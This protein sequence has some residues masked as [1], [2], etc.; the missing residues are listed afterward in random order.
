MFD[1]ATHG[2]A[3]VAV[4]FL[5][6]F[7][8][9]ACGL[10]F[11]QSSDT[12][13]E[14]LEA[15]QPEPA[16][17]RNRRKTAILLLSLLPA[18]ILISLGLIHP[19]VGFGIVVFIWLITGVFSVKTAYKNIS[20]PIILFLG[21]MLSIANILSSIGALEVITNPILP[22]VAS[23]PPFLLILSVL[24]VTAAISNFVD[25]SVSAVLMSPLVLQLYMTGAVAVSADALLMA[26]AAGAS[27]GIVIPT[28]QATLVVMNSTGF[29]KMSF[30]RT[31]A[32][33]LLLAALLASL[34]IS[35][36]WL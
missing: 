23:L 25:N 4:A 13:S 7:F 36:V 2:L 29:S 6:M 30:M 14:G 15:S 11:A 3:M 28:H 33:M 16:P 32:V 12:K 19:A 21:S 26:V 9:E 34:V 8:C 17:T 31:G 18:I 22:L 1:F 10:K 35:V 24:I 27:L 20:I 5:I